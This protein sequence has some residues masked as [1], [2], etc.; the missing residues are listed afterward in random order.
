LTYQLL[1]GILF[2]DSSDPAVA[3]NPLNVA[4][5]VI[6]VIGGLLLL[7][8]LPALYLNR[9][10]QGGVVW[11]IGNVLLWL[12]AVLFGVFLPLVFLLVF[13]VLASAA[14]DLLTQG[15]P[16]SFAPVF[17]V[18]TVANTLGAA[19]TAWAVLRARLYPSW[20]GWLLALEAILAALGFVF[21]GGSD[22]GIIGQ[23]LNVVSALPLFVVVGWIGYGLW[24]T[25][26]L[27]SQE[28]GASPR[29]DRQG[30]AAADQG[31]RA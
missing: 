2:P 20:I 5:S 13:P 28:V 18:G 10:A 31:T 9:A 30:L 12:T 8:G 7:F 14:P 11:F 3:M 19:F 25:S 17:I 15:P 6:G 23:M 24:T 29:L 27:T 4:L 26:L 1:S 21:Q 22:S 16:P